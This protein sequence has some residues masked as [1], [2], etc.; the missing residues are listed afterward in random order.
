MDIGPSD[1]PQPDALLAP[2]VHLTGVMDR[3]DG[4]GRHHRAAMAHR[5]ALLLLTEDLSCL[6]GWRGVG[7][8]V[9]IVGQLVGHWLAVRGARDDVAVGA[10]SV[11]SADDAADSEGRADGTPGAAD[12]AS[13][14]GEPLGV[15]V[16]LGV[17]EP[18]GEGEQ[19]TM[20]IAR[21][22]ANT[23]TR[24][25]TSSREHFGRA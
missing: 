15:G 5:V 24:G 14:S 21:H 12:G 10:A 25:V 19:P 6:E 8:P 9:A 11:A 7:L 23:L 1:D 18:L 2:T 20:R 17:G 22:A 4:I 13:A 16:P 3:E